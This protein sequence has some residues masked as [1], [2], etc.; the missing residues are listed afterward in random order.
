MD[1]RVGALLTGEEY[2]VVRVSVVDR[3]TVW[4]L[5]PAIREHVGS[6][7]PRQGVYELQ[8]TISPQKTMLYQKTPKNNVISVCA[9]ETHPSA[10]PGHPAETRCQSERARP[11]SAWAGP[12]GIRVLERQVCQTPCQ[13]LLLHQHLS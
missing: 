9:V 1:E 3:D 8:R 2:V 4:H 7:G 13:P 6:W 10:G 5:K 11:G 12:E